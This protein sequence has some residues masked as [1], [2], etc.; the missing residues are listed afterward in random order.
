MKSYRFCISKLCRVH[1]FPNNSRWQKH[2]KRAAALW[3]HSAIIFLIKIL[4]LSWYNTDEEI[5]SFSPT[6][7]F[8]IATGVHVG[9]CSFHSGIIGTQPRGYVFKCI[10]IFRK[11]FTRL[12]SLATIFRTEFY[13]NKAFLGKKP[14]NSETFWTPN[15]LLSKL[16]ETTQVTRSFLLL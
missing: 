15:N 7:A 6:Q 14:H 2:R 12:W 8:P 11:T 4:W 16:M 3:E 1:P 5:S 10:K 9:T 13:K